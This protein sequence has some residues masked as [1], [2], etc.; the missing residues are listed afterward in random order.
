MKHFLSIIVQ[1]LRDKAYYCSQTGNAEAAEALMEMA[2][3]FDDA[4]LNEF[5]DI[6]G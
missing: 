4:E 6:Q 1:R 2:E 5:I 3:V